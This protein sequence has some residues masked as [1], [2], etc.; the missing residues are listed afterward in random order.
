MY[1]PKSFQE[2]DTARLH[3][4]IRSRRLATLVSSDANGLCADHIPMLVETGDDGSTFL[5]G[6][7]ARANPLWRNLGMGTKALAIFHDAGGYITPSWYATKAESGKVVPTWNYVAV[8]V[9]GS[10]RAVDDPQW[11]HAFLTRLT[12]VNE[13]GRPQ[14]WRLTDAP[15]DYVATQLKA[16][17]GIE[18]AVTRM[19]GKWKM[20]QNRLPQ[21]IDGV[22][23]GL[24]SAGDPQSLRMAE[25]VEQRRP[26]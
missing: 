20:S 17:V 9:E 25:D 21:D 23:A 2:T 8:H 26:G 6:H 13:S 5:R 18:M 16:I 4:F 22:V 1:L 3:E 11:L 10:A 7:V 14:P 19:L 15:E 12:H 24:R